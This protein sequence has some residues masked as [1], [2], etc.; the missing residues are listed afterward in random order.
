[1]AISR[2]CIH[3]V[4]DWVDERNQGLFL[5]AELGNYNQ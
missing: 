4:G 3:L 5:E 2:H 1:M